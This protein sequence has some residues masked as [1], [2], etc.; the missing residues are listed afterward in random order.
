VPDRA[1]RRAAWAREGGRC[2]VTGCP[3]GGEDDDT[4]HLHHRRPFGMGGTSREDQDT[5]PNVIAVSEQVHRGIHGNPHW[6]GPDGLLLP[7]Q[8]ERSDPAAVP[9]RTWRGWV[10]LTV[11]GGYLPAS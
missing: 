7:K 6:S 3:L 5:L 2:V 1:L 4:W 9:V 10:F 11:E 8:G